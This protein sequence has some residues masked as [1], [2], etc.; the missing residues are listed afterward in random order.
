MKR[1]VVLLWFVLGLIAIGLLAGC[2]GGS[3]GTANLQIQL[4]PSTPT[5]TVDSSVLI[6]A[7]TTPVL[8]KYFGTMTWSVQGSSGCAAG[9]AEDPQNAPPLSPCPNGYVLWG[10]TPPPDIP[11]AVYYFSPS[12]PGTYQVNVQGQIT[13]TSGAVANQGSASAT[14]TVTAQ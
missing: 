11:T 9:V 10:L 5:V 2:G 4:A 12:S 8:S 13:N 7:Q 6:S 3:S 14:V 1:S